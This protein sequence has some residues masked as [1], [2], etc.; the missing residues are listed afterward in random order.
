MSGTRIDIMDD[1]VT[2]VTKMSDGNPG[3]I[4]VMMQLIKESE[5][6]D[7]DA[8]MGPLAHIL[9]LDSYGIYGSHIWI[10]YKDICGEDIVNTI[11][12]LRAVQLGLFKKWVLTK[13]INDIANGTPDES[14]VIDVSKLLTAVRKELVNFAQESS[15]S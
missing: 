9:D 12:V 7:P 5:S 15:G 10:L 11:A 3:A 6:I 14:E 2:I 4:S 1:L 8:A 13:A